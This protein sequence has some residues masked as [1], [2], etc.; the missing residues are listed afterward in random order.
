MTKAMEK[1]FWVWTR[2]D[3]SVS[4]SSVTNIKSSYDVEK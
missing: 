1:A 3:W 2:I 4:H